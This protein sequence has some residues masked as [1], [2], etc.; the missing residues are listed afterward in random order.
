[1]TRLFDYYRPD[2]VFHAAAYKHVPLMED[3]PS[4]AIY[5][6]VYGTKNI[7]DLSVKFNVKKF[8]FVSTDK[9][10]NPTNVRGLLKELL[11]Y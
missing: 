2:Y 5:T 3:N 8:V 4:E 6:N 10:V 11:K 9:A 1:M 7:V